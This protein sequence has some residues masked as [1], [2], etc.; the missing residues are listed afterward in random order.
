MAIDLSGHKVP[1]FPNINDAPIAP[2]ATKAGNGA[3]LIARLNGLID[4]LAFL[5]NSSNAVTNWTVKLP[6]ETDYAR[7]EIYYK[8]DSEK[9]IY[10]AL[11]S[12]TPIIFGGEPNKTF[13]LGVDANLFCELGEVH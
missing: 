1:V 9:N 3:D 13:T 6:S 12:Q 4:A 11:E 8:S 7:I 5:V 10:K 2:I